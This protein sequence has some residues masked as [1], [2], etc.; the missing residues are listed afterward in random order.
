L[1][2]EIVNF[3]YFSY[4]YISKLQPINDLDFHPQGTILISGAKDQT[5]KYV[6]LLHNMHYSH[7][8]VLFI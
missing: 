1:E 5:I 4:M 6:F 3:I 8:Y 2:I 7:V